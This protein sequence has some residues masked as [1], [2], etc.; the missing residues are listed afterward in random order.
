[1]VKW[2]FVEMRSRCTAERACRG[3]AGAK[4]RAG[5]EAKGLTWPDI[6]ANAGFRVLAAG[7]AITA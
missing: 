2:R 5:L 4:E 3:P 6:S 1:M 7:V